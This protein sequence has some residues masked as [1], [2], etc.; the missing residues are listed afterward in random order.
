MRKLYLCLG[1]ALVAS[2]V[3]PVASADLC[4]TNYPTTASCVQRL[5]P[6]CFGPSV[7]HR[8]ECILLFS[9]DLCSML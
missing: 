5:P 3:L 6:N 1:L 9:A 7:W 4:V 2:I 8:S